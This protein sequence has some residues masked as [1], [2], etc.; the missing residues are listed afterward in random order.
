MR[1]DESFLE[2]PVRSLQTML[3]VLAEDDRRVPTVV[4]D[5]IYGPTTMQSVSAIQRKY[6]IPATGIADQQ[7]WEAIAVAYEDALIRVDKAEPIEIVMD[8]GRI[9]RM[10]EQG[11]YI[12]LLQSILIQLS[13]EHPSIPALAHTGIFD[14]ET[15]NALSAFQQLAELPATGELDKITW[16]NLSRQYTLFAQHAEHRQRALLKD[17]KHS[18]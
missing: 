12:Y 11:P 9:Y 18:R 7:T 13:D 14:A 1:P 6:G 2:Q 16:K 3:R 15:A 4:P 8:A 10:G 17:P 5:G